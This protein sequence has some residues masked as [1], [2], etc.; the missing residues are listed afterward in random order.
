MQSIALA[1]LFKVRED[2]G[3]LLNAFKRK[4]RFRAKTILIVPLRLL[5]ECFDQRIG[6][7]PEER[8][9]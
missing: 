4:D 5:I 1:Q 8:C 6:G 2:L 9:Q 3:N 7:G